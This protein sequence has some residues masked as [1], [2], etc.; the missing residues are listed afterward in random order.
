MASICSGAAR[1]AWLSGS[2][3]GASSCKKSHDCGWARS[4]GHPSDNQALFYLELIRTGVHHTDLEP[5]IA[6][7][8]DLRLDGELHPISERERLY[9]VV[10]ALE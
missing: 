5:V 8:G 6:Q 7:R 4:R 3:Y 1:L 10:A 9:N 2:V